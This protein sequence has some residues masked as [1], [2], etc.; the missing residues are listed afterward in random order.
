MWHYD[1]ISTNSNNFRQIWNYIQ[2]GLVT[3]GT[4][5]ANR[6]WSS[7]NHL[8]VLIQCI[9]L[10]CSCVVLI[11]KVWLGCSITENL[12]DSFW[13]EILHFLS[14]H[15]FCWQSLSSIIGHST[16]HWEYTLA[17]TCCI[18]YLLSLLIQFLCTVCTASCRM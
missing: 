6:M 14:A 11:V 12:H 2:R 3:S 15:W 8:T 18:R 5:V 9:T 10:L 1:P 4:A 7:E 13:H 17:M 16:L